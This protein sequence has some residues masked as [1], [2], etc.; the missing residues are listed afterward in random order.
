MENFRPLGALRPKHVFVQNGKG[1]IRI[2]TNELP[3]TL[4]T[5]RERRAQL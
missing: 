2:E 3:R 1:R 5:V 4:F